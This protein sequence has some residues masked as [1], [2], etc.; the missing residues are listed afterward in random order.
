GRALDDLTRNPCLPKWVQQAVAPDLAGV[1]PSS[2]R[3]APH[4]V[5]PADPWRPPCGPL[6]SALR[7]LGVRP[8]DPWRPPYGPLASALRTLGV[9]PAC[10]WRPPCGPLASVPRTPSPL[11]GPC[12]S[13]TRT[14]PLT[15]RRGYTRRSPVDGRGALWGSLSTTAFWRP[16]IHNPV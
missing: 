3:L 1:R 2:G 9:R 4:T 10:P 7:T 14:D 8:A 5:R 6:A 13:V 16:V 11:Y 12:P 15:V